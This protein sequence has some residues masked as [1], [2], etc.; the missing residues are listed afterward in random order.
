[1][2]VNLIATSFSKM[3][4]LSLQLLL[5]YVPK[6]IEILSLKIKTPYAQNYLE[7][8][9]NVSPMPSY[10]ILMCQT[11]IKG[12]RVMYCIKQE[13]IFITKADF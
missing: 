6:L 13:L 2:H 7:K 3:G 11:K 10:H 9:L 5:C 4:S 8:K 12:L 1:V